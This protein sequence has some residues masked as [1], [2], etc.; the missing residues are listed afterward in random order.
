[1]Y[2]L[3]PF[4]ILTL[5]LLNC[6]ASSMVSD[7][8]SESMSTRGWDSDNSDKDIGY[9]DGPDEGKKFKYLEDGFSSS[10][11]GGD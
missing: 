2:R 11:D 4:L 10:S 3:L 8:S 6:L 1:M 9:S 5:L 7:D